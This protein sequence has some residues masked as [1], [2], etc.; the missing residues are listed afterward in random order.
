MFVNG[1]S[2]VVNVL[3]ISPIDFPGKFFL[4]GPACSEG[5]SHDH[6]PGP[7]D[8]LLDKVPGFLIN[9]A[10]FVLS[11]GKDWLSFVSCFYCLI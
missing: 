2:I 1:H 3:Y 7:S 8:K 6:L 5:I 4:H 10:C 9:I 11:T